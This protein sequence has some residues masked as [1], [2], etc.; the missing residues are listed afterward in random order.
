MHFFNPVHRMPLVEVV[1]TDRS[2]DTAVATVLAAVRKLDKTPVVVRD[3][4][5]F[6]V[7]RVLAPYMNEAG[8]LLADGA[9]IEEVDAALVAFGM[10]MGPLRLLDEVGL[11]VARH[12]ADS[13]HAAFGERMAPAPPLLA[14]RDT[15]LVG[16]KGGRGFYHYDGPGGQEEDADEELRE[17]IA[18]DADAG[19]PAEAI[20]QR[21]LLAMVNEAARALEDQVVAGP[22]SVDLAMIMGTGFPP[23]RGG[24][25]RWADARGTVRVM[26]DLEALR[27]QHGARFTPAPLIE[28]L[29]AVD[30]PFYPA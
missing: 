2:G 22:G 30:A 23:F 6:L 27:A 14:L 21:C 8:W 13:L 19:P 11:D 15:D 4:P 3:A 26:A 25:L 29:C 28:R 7:N 9:G 1:R 20:R 17:R 18:P 16:R 5:G 24:L 10:P 12:A